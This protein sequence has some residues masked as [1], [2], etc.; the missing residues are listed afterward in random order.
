MNLN[1]QGTVIEA[2]EYTK[3]EHTDF[4]HVSHSMQPI[5]TTLYSTSS[6]SSLSDISLIDMNDNGQV[7]VTEPQ[8][9][10]KE[11]HAEFERVSHSMQHIDTNSHSTS[12]G[13]SLSVIALIY[14]NING[15]VTV[16]EPQSY[17]EEEPNQIIGVTDSMQHIDT[18]S[19]S[20]SIN[21][22]SLSNSNNDIKDNTYCIKET[23]TFDQAS[24]KDM[25]NYDYRSKIIL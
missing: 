6:G 21:M 2:Q 24:Y 14:M 11:G 7:T 20:F 17:T 25:A 5:G 13:A 4:E 16:T 1:T 18:T 8:E 12:S 22:A 19:H 23:K 10:T 9:Y 3:E 15:Q